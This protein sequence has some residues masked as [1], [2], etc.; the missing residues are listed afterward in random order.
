ME[1][2]AE[3]AKEKH[4][5]TE[6]YIVG[7]IV[8]IYDPVWKCHV[9]NVFEPY[10]PFFWF[11]WKFFLH[12]SWANWKNQ[13]LKKWKKDLRY[14][15]HT[16]GVNWAIPR[17]RSII[18]SAYT[19]LG[20]DHRVVIDKSFYHKISSRLILYLWFFLKF[21]FTFQL[22]KLKKP[23]TGEMKKR[24]FEIFSGC[25]KLR[26]SRRHV[27]TFR[28]PPHFTRF[29]LMCQDFSS[30]SFLMYIRYIGE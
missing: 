4:L 19:R 17:S 30:L 12:F 20:L 9:Y 10:L 8:D 22:D 5:Q 16:L 26:L 15:Q 27:F 1:Q 7:C 21:F 25:D 2:V 28:T 13:C 24:F 18:F 3:P 29:S 11:F 14:S 6:C 23:M